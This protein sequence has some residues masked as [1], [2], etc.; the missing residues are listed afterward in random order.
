[1][2]WP[3]N[4]T[5][6][7]RS[8]WSCW[9]IW[10]DQQNILRLYKSSQAKSSR[11]QGWLLQIF[12]TD[13]VMLWTTSQ[14]HTQ[15]LEEKEWPQEEQSERSIEQCPSDEPDPLKEGN[16]CQSQQK[17]RDAGSE[18]QSNRKKNLNTLKIKW[19]REESKQRQRWIYN[20]YQEKCV[21]E[22][23]TIWTHVSLFQHSQ[24]LALGTK[25]SNPISSPFSLLYITNT[26]RKEK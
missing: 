6:C 19:K 16:S 15:C 26:K 1:M 4:V 10:R 25:N 11:G 20:F 24:A 17:Q 12:A 3:C 8:S 7:S 23:K 2:T 22:G 14:V 18:T 13:A 9:P 5:T 21:N